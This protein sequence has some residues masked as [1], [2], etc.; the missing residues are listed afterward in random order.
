[1]NRRKFLQSGSVAVLAQSL[2]LAAARA[3]EGWRTFET[4]RRVEVKEAFGVARPWA[5]LPLEADTDWHKTLGNTW[6]GNAARAVVEHDGK[7]G[8]GMVY[9]EWR[10]REMN[11]VVEVTSRFLTRDRAMDFSQPGSGLDPL[12]AER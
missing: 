8:I 6:S 7:Y 3:Q 11:P 2:P 4:L 5:P 12:P 9:T 1:M 10:A